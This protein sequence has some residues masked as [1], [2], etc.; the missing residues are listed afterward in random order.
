MEDG[1]KILSSLHPNQ[2]KALFFQSRIVGGGILIAQHPG[3][4]RRSQTSVAAPA[5]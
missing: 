4:L 2:R 3:D 5:I 1:R